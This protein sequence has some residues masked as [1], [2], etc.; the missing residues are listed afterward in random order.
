MSVEVVVSAVD[1]LLTALVVNFSVFSEPV[2][3]LFLT[4]DAVLIITEIYIVVVCIR[5]L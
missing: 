3:A 5:S 2:P 4:I 1:L